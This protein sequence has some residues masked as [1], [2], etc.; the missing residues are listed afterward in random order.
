MKI[1]TLLLLFA[2]IAT[3]YSQEEYTISGYVK[4][5]ESGETLIGATVAVDKTKKGAVTNAYGFYSI[6]LASGE[7]S[8]ITSYI[9]FNKDSS[10]VNL[11]KDIKLDI[12]LGESSVLSEEVVVSSRKSDENIV[13]IEMSTL[14]LSQATLTRMPALLG[15]SDVIRSVQLLPGVSTVGEGATGFNVRGGG[16]DQNLVLLDE[17][18]VYNSSHL[19][20]FFS[21]FNPDAVK[22]VK[23]I[24][25]GIPAKYGGRLS[26]ILNVRLKEGN[27]RKYNVDGG[28]GAI[29]SRL[30]VEGPIIEDKLSFL[31]AG[32]RSYIDVLAKPFLDDDLSDS[33][34]YFYDL[35]AKLNWKIDENNTIFTSGYF[36]RDVFNAGFGFDWGSQTA[37]VRWNHLFSDQLFSNLTYYFSN[38]DYKLQF[39]EID[40]GEYFRWQSNIIT[41]SVK[42]DLEYFLNPNN[43]IDFGLEGIYYDFVPGIA[44]G[45]TDGQIVQIELDD[46]FAA[47]LSGYV[48]QEI[49]FTDY[50]SMQ[51]GLRGSFYSYLGP[52][53]AY[54]YGDTTL[55]KQKPVNSTQVY[56]DFESISDY[57][58]L[59]PRASLKYQINEES[60]VKASY[61]R[62]A[63]YVHLLSST[64]AAT[65]LDIWVPTTNNV[66]PELADQYALGYFKNFDDNS[67]ETSV[68]VYYKD[69]QNQVDYRNGADLTLNEFYEG[70]L[71]YGD[72]RAYGAEF[73]IKKNSGDFTGWI[74]YTLA[75][76]ER[77]IAGINNGDWYP[78]RFDR[79]HN[80]NL[81][82][83][84][85]L[86]DTWSF[87]ANFILASG[88]PA[89]FPNQRFEF[90][91]YTTPHNSDNARGNY[92]I[93]L[94]HRLDLSATYDPEDD[95][96]DWWSGKWVF[97]IYNV[98]NRKNPY[99]VFFR[100]NESDYSQTEA[101][102]FAVFGTIVP[103][104]S[105]NFNFDVNK[106]VNE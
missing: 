69:F 41:Q 6:T 61:N 15:E 74:S 35:T 25:G 2:T 79:T 53:T 32:R 17:A 84:Y 43:S 23:L 48:S 83:F 30:A 67:W 85:D 88:T 26:S 7:Y 12:E 104:V 39:G 99:S 5:A 50:F 87:S 77:N 34:F 102:R 44:D 68:E 56:D 51:Y 22:D 57:F 73:Y 24:K 96:D 76:T 98:Y 36:G 8:I 9:G 70:D 103:A 29:F 81:V 31:V 63:Q 11:N 19:F 45:G 72:G 93:G 52:G 71:L 14:E 20:G 60:S 38:Y 16:I 55:G 18:P 66:K 97:S 42:Y 33:Q 94:S 78:T 47:Q 106:L 10:F 105:Y 75:K 3:G 46:Q 100:N 82:G 49:D 90:Q 80:L 64:A 40:E 58:N 1:I 59:E 62:M 4:D 95:P 65:P 21:V 37:T 54:T 92:R 28:V 27:Q 86:S 13:S 89:T 91:G 101:V